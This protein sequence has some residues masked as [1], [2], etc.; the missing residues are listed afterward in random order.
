MVCE[1][2]K[3]KLDKFNCIDVFVIFF[4]KYFWVLNVIVCEI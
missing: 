3:L 2:V 1:S 4:K